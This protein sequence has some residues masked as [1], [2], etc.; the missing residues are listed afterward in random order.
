MGISRTTGIREI[1][2]EGERTTMTIEVAGEIVTIIMT[3]ATI[4]IAGIDTTGTDRM[5]GRLIEEEIT[6]TIIVLAVGETTGMLGMLLLGRTTTLIDR[7]TCATI[8]TWITT[9]LEALLA[10]EIVDPNPLCLA[11]SSN[12]GPDHRSHGHMPLNANM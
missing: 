6:T 3:I 12:L 7:G 1:V 8:E 11:L 9:E 5:R 10:K 2:E 4:E